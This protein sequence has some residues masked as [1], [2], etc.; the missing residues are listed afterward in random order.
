[1]ISAKQ[2]ITDIPI[3]SPLFIQ[4]LIQWSKVLFHHKLNPSFLSLF[5]WMIS[6]KQWITD[7]PIQSPLFIPFQP[8]QLSHTTIIHHQVIDKSSTFVQKDQLQLWSFH[9][10]KFG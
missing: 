5:Q 9:V 6:A 2:W 10:N 1:M 4:Q 8:E 7:I 3:Q